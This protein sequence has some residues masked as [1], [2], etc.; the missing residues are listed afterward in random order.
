MVAIFCLIISS[1]CA[2]K[3]TV[4]SISDEET[5][6]ERATAYWSYRINREFDKTYEYEYNPDKLLD[7]DK[8]MELMYKGTV[9]YKGYDSMTVEKRTD[10]NAE[11]SL[12]M[13]MSMTVTGTRAFEHSMIIKDKWVRE[14][15]IWYHL[16]GI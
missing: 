7:K 8:Y 14:D 16:I 10:G 15:G 12:A 9:R 11:L 2:T 3:E 1:G 6:K 5:L 4:K 13:K